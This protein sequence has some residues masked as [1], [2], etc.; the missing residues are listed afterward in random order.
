MKA[1]GKADESGVGNPEHNKGSNTQTS[2]FMLARIAS[3]WVASTSFLGAGY[4]AQ[5]VFFVPLN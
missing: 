5:L 1:A 3:G 2:A 4:A